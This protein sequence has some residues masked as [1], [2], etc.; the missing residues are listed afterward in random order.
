MIATD[1][2]FSNLRR[3]RAS[4]LLLADNSPDGAGLSGAEIQREIG[5]SGASAVIR[6]AMENGAIQTVMG[7]SRVGVNKGKPQRKKLAPEVEE[8]IAALDEAGKFTRA[9]IARRYGISG[10]TVTRIV[11]RNNPSR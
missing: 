8:K 1:Q 7:Q 6:R 10:S 2:Q 9:E 11:D 4:I 5:V 3:R